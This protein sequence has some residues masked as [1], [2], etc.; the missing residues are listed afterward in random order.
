MQTLMTRNPD[1]ISIATDDGWKY[2]AVRT[3]RA[4]KK[5]GERLGQ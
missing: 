5:Q 4:D 1:L 3:Q 2:E